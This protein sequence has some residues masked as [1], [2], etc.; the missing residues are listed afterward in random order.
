MSL[1]MNGLNSEGVGI[2]VK[3]GILGFQKSGLTS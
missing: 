2:F 1:E 3:A